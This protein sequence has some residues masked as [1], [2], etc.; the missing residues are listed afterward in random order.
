M[1]NIGK[2][3][4]R[5]GA[6]LYVLWGLLHLYAAWL[7]FQLGAPIVDAVVQSK[8]YQ[9]GWNLGFASVAVIL[10]AILMNWR[11]SL[12][13]FWINAI[14]VST[15]DIGFMVLIYFPGVA[16]DLLGPALWILA[17]ACTIFGI[18]KAERTP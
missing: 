13:G 12:R 15:L 17:L 11:N 1:T 18:L 2:L 14:L 9:N 5:A 8:L 16:T 4:Y 10:V 3:A 7:S 6:T